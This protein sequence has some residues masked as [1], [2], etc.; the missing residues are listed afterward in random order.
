MRQKTDGDVLAETTWLF[1]GY[2]A[3]LLDE[4]MDSLRGREELAIYKCWDCEYTL[5]QRDIPD[6]PN[7]GAHF[8]W[9][10]PTTSDQSPR[11]VRP[12][13]SWVISFAV[14]LVSIVAPLACLYAVTAY[15]TT[16]LLT[17]AGEILA[18]AVSDMIE[19]NIQMQESIMESGFGVQHY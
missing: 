14:I 13:I 19:N 1:F 9:G 5:A 6:C 15:S 3:W 4:Y 18:A 17:R 7:C 12:P 8:H 16:Y 2:G 10:N 11:R